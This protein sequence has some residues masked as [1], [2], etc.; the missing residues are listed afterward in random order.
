MKLT[1][2]LTEKL[3]LTGMY[4]LIDIYEPVYD[5]GWN[6][7]KEA[8]RVRDHE[9]GTTINSILTWVIDQ[10]TLAEARFG[11]VN[12]FFPLYMQPGTEENIR[13]VCAITGH[14]WGSTLRDETYT[15]RRL[16]PSVSLT[17]FQD[18]FLGGNHEF[19]L[20]F[21]YEMGIGEWDWWRKN[22]IYLWS[23]WGALPWRYHTT[24][25]YM[26]LFYAYVCGQN[27]GDNYK[28]DQAWRVG[29]YAQDSYTIKGRLTFN[30]GIRYDESHSFRPALKRKGTV[31]TYN[32]GLLNVILPEIFRTTDINIDE[33]K[34]IHVWKS[35]SPRIAAAYDLFGNGKTALRASFS[36]YTEYIMLTY[37]SPITDPISPIAAGFYWYDDNK[38][39][40]LDL[41]PVDRYTCF[42]MP[43]ILDKAEI[44][45]ERVDPNLKAPY[46]DEYTAGIEHEL[47]KDFSIGL[48][49]IYKD[50]RRIAEGI[51]K[52]NP[53][54]GDM[55]VPYPVKDPGWDG[56]FGTGDDQSITAYMC[57]KEALPTVY[58]FTNPPDIKRRYQALE[59]I[60]NKRMSNRWQLGGSIV[61]SKMYGHLGGDYGST[62]G[63]F[64]GDQQLPNWYIN[65]YGRLDYDRPLQIKLQGT[66]ILPYQ[67]LLSA[68]YR[69]F[70]GV[71]WARTL[72]I[73]FP[74]T[75]AGFARKFAS[76]TILAEPSGTRRTESS[77]VLDLR[78]E[79]EFQLGRFGKVG[80][81]L[82]IFNV[83][84]YTH[85]TIVQDPGGDILADGRFVR[86]PTYGKITGASGV[87]S[88]KLGLRYSF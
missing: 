86:Y 55:W 52:N 48:N 7:P 18:D 67:I 24:T 62:W 70:S 20:G 75:Y 82:D 46:T 77:D 42:S 80:A 78:V 36:R 15:R 4:Q 76:V 84:G 32:N 31:D 71:P 19:K 39:G 26:G 72:R 51:D 61:Y 50:K 59:L 27:S 57:K 17:R 74:A 88:F 3:K 6:L 49:Y 87:R 81:F 5:T 10:N 41:P 14:R 44:V 63:Y 30:I 28:R 53:V 56:I 22:P 54:G 64:A 8:A 33:V 60:F 47:F 23:Y 83:M 1:A 13:Y 25:P 12:R 45:R 29:F 58:F 68:Y 21:D 65:R 40:K 37:V 43:A 79:K 11:Y 9:K 2:R 66:V 69:H 16:N 73:N 34:D 85:W 38:N 35:L